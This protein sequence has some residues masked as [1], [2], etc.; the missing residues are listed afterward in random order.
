MSD[1][2]DETLRQGLLALGNAVELHGRRIDRLCDTVNNAPAKFAA[3]VGANTD[4][5]QR[6]I[7]TIEDERQDTAARFERLE[8][9]VARLKARHG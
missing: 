6:L 7:K 2:A 8:K 1:T 9:E 3:T 4:A 5:V